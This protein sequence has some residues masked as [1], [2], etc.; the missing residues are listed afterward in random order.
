M[1]AATSN[2][3]L[4][5]HLISNLQ[6]FLTWWYGEH[7]VVLGMEVVCNHD[8]W[9]NTCPGVYINTIATQVQPQSLSQSLHC[10]TKYN[11]IKDLCPKM[12]KRRQMRCPYLSGW[13]LNVYIHS[14]LT[15]YTY[16]MNLL[17]QFG[18]DPGMVYF[19]PQPWMDILALDKT[20][21]FK[22]WPPS[23]Y[24]ALPLQVTAIITSTRC[25]WQECI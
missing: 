17:S 22:W 20:I 6:K 7:Q 9:T 25:H 1:A 3:P 5:E 12:M 4:N 21:T 14:H 19:A 18:G 15:Q 11:T 10:L 2:K 16:A 24:A 13:I 8:T 23:I